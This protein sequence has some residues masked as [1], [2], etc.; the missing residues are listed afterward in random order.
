MQYNTRMLLVGTTFV[1]VVVHL[2]AISQA[3]TF[4]RLVRDLILLY[5]GTILMSLL[6]ILGANRLKR[7]GSMLGTLT[8]FVLWGVITCQ[9]FAYETDASQFVGL[10]C[11]FLGA[12]AVTID[13]LIFLD[14]SHDATV[15][16]QI[17]A[18]Q[19]IKTMQIAKRQRSSRV[20]ALQQ[21][22]EIPDD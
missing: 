22:T 10:Q 4:E 14:L 11:L 16:Q 19:F 6:E 12:V 18:S 15:E 3:L 8:G 21:T 1:A 13:R 5:L 7:I 20:K 2:V 9:I 17:P